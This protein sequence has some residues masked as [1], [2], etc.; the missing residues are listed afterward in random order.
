[1]AEADAVVETSSVVFA[2]VDV[3]I[4][5][6]LSVPGEVVLLTLFAVVVEVGVVI[7]TPTSLPMS[8]S[9]LP[10]PLPSPSRSPGM[11]LIPPAVS[12][13]EPTV[14]AVS[15]AVVVEEVLSLVEVEVATVVDDSRSMNE[16]LLAACVSVTVVPTVVVDSDVVD[17]VGLAEDI[18]LS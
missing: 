11:V 18:V 17:V 1:M 13:V 16:E 2:D 14:V 4:I 12:V 7:S 9:P 15:S 10:S 5:V 3:V 6:V 8:S